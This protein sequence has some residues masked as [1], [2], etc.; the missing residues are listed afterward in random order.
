VSRSDGGGNNARKAP[1]TP[2]TIQA[3]DNRVK[4]NKTQADV[5]CGYR[6]LY[7]LNSGGGRD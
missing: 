6:S 5:H 4:V 1:N 7:T 3:I 2:L